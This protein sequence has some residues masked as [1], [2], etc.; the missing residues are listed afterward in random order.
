MCDLPFLASRS[1]ARPRISAL[2]AAFAACVLVLGLLAAT[3][4]AGTTSVWRV[5]APSGAT[6]F[7]AGSIHLLP[8]DYGALPKAFDEAFAA[9]E[10]VVFEA[11]IDPNAIIAEAQ[12]LLSMGM[13]SGDRSLFDALDEATARALRATAEELGMPASVMGRLK[14][15][16]AGVT[17]TGLALRDAG[18]DAES[19]VDMRLQRRAVAADKTIITLETVE[20]QLRLLADLDEATQVAFL[21]QAIAERNTIRDMADQLVAAWESGRAESL[22]AL[23]NEQLRAEPELAERLLYARNEQWFAEL[24]RLAEDGATVMVVVGAGHLV[25]TRGLVQLFADDGYRVKQL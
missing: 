23:V 12:R 6:V 8:A 21:E 7:L 24:E 2:G 19:G 22:N 5:T 20:E 4:Q 11:D 13:Y 1:I 9:S 17:I 10:T 25:G 15:W 16:F 3:A 14:P 18:F